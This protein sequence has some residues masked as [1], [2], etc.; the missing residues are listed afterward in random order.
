MYIEPF[1]TPTAAA[2]PNPGRPKDA[3]PDPAASC[4]RARHDRLAAARA[5][6]ERA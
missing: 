2:K 3:W 6:R 1:V 4:L 5:R